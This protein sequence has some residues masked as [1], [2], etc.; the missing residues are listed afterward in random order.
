MAD[1][2]LA[3]QFGPSQFSAEG[4]S[5]YVNTM[6]E[7]WVQLANESKIPIYHPGTS[8]ATKSQTGTPS[9]ADVPKFENV[10]DEVDGAL[11]I[12]AH[13]SGPN[14]AAK[15]RSTAL[16]LLYGNYLNGETTTSADSIR[17]ACIDQGCYDSSNFASHLRG[18]K[19]KIAMNTKPGGGYDVKL[20]APGRKA[21]LDFVEQLN[22]GAT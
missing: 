1:V 8:D 16:A 19:E 4:P 11:K 2:K 17:D 13:I 15:T 7:R 3:M 9:G 21:A 6:L 22:N 5:D 12:I 18:L 14:K 10:Y 20:T